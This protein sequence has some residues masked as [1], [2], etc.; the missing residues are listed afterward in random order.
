M[1]LHG[2]L[3][4]VHVLARRTTVSTLYQN[5]VRPRRSLNGTTPKCQWK[6]TAMMTTRVSSTSPHAHTPRNFH[7]RTTDMKSLESVHST[8]DNV[9]LRKLHTTNI[10]STF[11]F[12]HTWKRMHTNHHAQ[13]CTKATNYKHE[14]QN[15][16]LTK[17][18]S[19]NMSTVNDDLMT[20]VELFTYVHHLCKL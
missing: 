11:P 7:P 10:N 19:L 20:Y 17:R 12:E 15:L 6:K 8:I 14:W 2:V 1:Y 9:V 3:T 5:S 4:C 18:L 16:Y 13:L